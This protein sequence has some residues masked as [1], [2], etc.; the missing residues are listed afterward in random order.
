MRKIVFVSF[1]LF[2]LASSIY[3]GEFYNCIDRNGNTI[4]TN[5]PQDGMKKC[6]LK[7]SYRDPAP[8]AYPHSYPAPAQ[9]DSIPRRMASSGSGSGYTMCADGSY[10]PGSQCTMCADGSYVGGSRCTMTP[11]GSYVGGSRYTMTPNG[12]YVAGSQS[13][14]CADGSYVGGSRC[15]MTPDGKYVGGN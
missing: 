11:N 8:P 7:E 10:V 3:A 14:M 12:S 9:Q 15:T 5:S 6:V 2:I 4:L 1:I 13:T